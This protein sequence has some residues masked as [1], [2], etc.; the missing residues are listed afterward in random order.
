MFSQGL[1]WR[2]KE[3]FFFWRGRRAQV[4][5]RGAST[6]PAGGPAWTGG[7]RI[8]PY[9]IPPFL[10]EPE[11]TGHQAG[12]SPTGKVQITPPS[13]QKDSLRRRRHAAGRPA[14]VLLRV[15]RACGRGDLRAHRWG[16]FGAVGA[17]HAPPR[18]HAGVLLR[19]AAAAKAQ[20]SSRQELRR[21]PGAAAARPRHASPR[22]ANSTPPSPHPQKTQR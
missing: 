15:H 14:P 9:R 6:G 19:G 17:L 3:R 16:W 5:A 11:R 2:S 12:G 13:N 8:G 7:R 21:H 18:T 22:L 4:L 1:E 10:I 20:L